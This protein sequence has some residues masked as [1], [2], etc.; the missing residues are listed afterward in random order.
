MLQYLQKERTLDWCSQGY[1]YLG[2]EPRPGVQN[3]ELLETKLPFHSLKQINHMNY[4]VICPR[5]MLLR[6]GK[7]DQ[8]GHEFFSPC[9]LSETKNNTKLPGRGK[10]EARST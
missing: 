5:T 3:T 1:A 9:R 2:S 10:V 4:V 8:C 6:M 7:E